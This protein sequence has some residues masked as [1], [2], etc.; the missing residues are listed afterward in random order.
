MHRKVK[1]Y[2]LNLSKTILII[3]I[4]GKYQ[5]YNSIIIEY[6]YG[7]IMTEATTNTLLKPFWNHRQLTNQENNKRLA[8]FLGFHNNPPFLYNRF[9]LLPL[10]KVN[11]NSNNRSWIVYNPNCKIMPDVNDEYINVQINS[12]I[13]IRLKSKVDYI[14]RQKSRAFKMK[15][16]IEHF[17]QQILFY[18]GNEYNEY[19]EYSRFKNELIEK[20]SIIDFINYSTSVS[21]K[22]KLSE[23]E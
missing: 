7:F 3:D 8:S 12:S 11:R 10:Q 14:L 17:I 19:L 1:N 13:S 5:K 4:K 16:T 2:Q 23:Y 6:P 9:L 15:C 20:A 22:N 21:I 18:W